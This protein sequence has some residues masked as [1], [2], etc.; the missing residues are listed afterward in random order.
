VVE[1]LAAADRDRGWQSVGEAGPGFL[2]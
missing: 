2:D 1:A